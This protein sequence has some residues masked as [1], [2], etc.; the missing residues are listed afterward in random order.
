MIVNSEIK[1]KSKTMV[2]ETENLVLDFILYS[3]NVYKRKHLLLVIS[4]QS[5]Y[6]NKIH[7]TS[8]ELSERVKNLF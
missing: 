4:G 8:L 5:S 6:K 1:Q 7:Y 2:G 3:V